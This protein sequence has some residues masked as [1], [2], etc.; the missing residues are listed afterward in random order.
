MGPYN[1]DGATDDCA[2]VS[3]VVPSDDKCENPDQSFYVES[4]DEYL[5]VVETLAL[6]SPSLSEPH[7]LVRSFLKLNCLAVTRARHSK[8]CRTV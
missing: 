6:D 1:T 7:V 4:R 3:D 2:G 8:V 5:D